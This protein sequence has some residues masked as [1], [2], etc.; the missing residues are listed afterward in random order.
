MFPPTFSSYE[1]FGKH[2]NPDEIREMEWQKQVMETRAYRYGD[3]VNLKEKIQV[4]APRVKKETFQVR[5]L[6][7]AFALLRSILFTN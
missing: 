4:E 7:F 1:T 2:R 3:P 6:K 5:K